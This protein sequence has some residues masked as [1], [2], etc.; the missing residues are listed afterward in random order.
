VPPAFPKSADMTMVRSMH[1]F[2]YQLLSSVIG[3]KNILVRADDLSW[4]SVF[5]CIDS[6][7]HHGLGAA[8]ETQVQ[9]FGTPFEYPVRYLSNI[10][11][12]AFAAILI[13]LICHFKTASASFGVCRKTRGW[14][15]CPP[16]THFLS[17]SE[18]FVHLVGSLL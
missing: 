15:L 4:M 2:S 7:Q 17:R 12:V 18:G 8:E 1:V 9:C 13:I 16:H 14:T 5:R 3:L 11:L 6:S 10:M